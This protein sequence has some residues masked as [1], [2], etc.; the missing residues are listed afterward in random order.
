[1]ASSQER[2]I[3]NVIHF[4]GAQTKISA[5]LKDYKQHAEAVGG[6]NLSSSKYDVLELCGFQSS[7]R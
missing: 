3:Q 1:M 4:H 6:T 2:I 7:K 5:N